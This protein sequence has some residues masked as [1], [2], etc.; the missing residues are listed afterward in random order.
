[1]FNLKEIVFSYYNNKKTVDS[2]D[3]TVCKTTRKIYR[4]NICCGKLGENY[5]DLQNAPP[6]F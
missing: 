6:Q 3:E 4:H 5:L 2:D 1:M